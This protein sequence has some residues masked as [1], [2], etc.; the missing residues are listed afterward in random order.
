MTFNNNNRAKDGVHF[1]H[2][3]GF[4]TRLREQSFAVGT[5]NKNPKTCKLN[6]C[7]TLNKKPSPSP[8]KPI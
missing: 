8:L 6:H 2:L 4:T 5:S 3:L 1:Y 7:A